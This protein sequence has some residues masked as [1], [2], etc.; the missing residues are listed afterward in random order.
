VNDS[1]QAL[2]RLPDRTEIHKRLQLIFPDGTLNR[3]YCV[4]EIAASTVFAMMYIGAIEGTG[5]F[6]AP[7]HVYL[8][9]DEQ[10]ALVDA[11]SR[12]RYARESSR[13]GFVASGKRWYKDNSREPIRDETLREGFIPLGAVVTRPGIP[14]TSS[15]PRYALAESFAGLFDPK[16]RGETLVTKISAWQGENLSASARARITLV[17][18]GVV[19]TTEGMLVAFPNGET[20]R[21]APGPSSVIAKALV[22]DFAPRFLGRPG[23]LWL[24][25]S[26]K[27]VV[28]RDDALARRL[29]LRIE[30]DRNLPD[31][32][33]VDLEPSSPLFVF[34]EIVATDGAVTESRQRA[35]LQIATQAG[36]A[37]GQVAFLTA[38]SDRNAPGFRRTVTT[39]AWRS[40][41]WFVSEPEHIIVLRDGAE[42]PVRLAELLSVVGGKVITAPRTR[43]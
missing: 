14:T 12:Q 18:H 28:H 36:F 29:G 35:L 8:M 30:A 2:P 34:V 31:S 3:G 20:R 22:E 24:S 1:T 37:Q 4:R 32:I 5:R 21:L 15:K 42:H 7:K 43:D 13:P 10:S 9:T 27:K 19:G 40:F 26:E 11:E 17:R 16:L 38:Y 25:E 33:L 6:L 23:V 41:A 39:L